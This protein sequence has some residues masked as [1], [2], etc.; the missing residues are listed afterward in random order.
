VSWIL[1]WYE[2]VA[3]CRL[4]IALSSFKMIATTAIS[5]AINERMASID[6]E[7]AVFVCCRMERVGLASPSPKLDDVAINMFQ[8]FP[9]PTKKKKKKRKSREVSG[10]IVEKMQREVNK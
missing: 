7:E 8:R 5:R 6:H 4:L 9:R 3:I 2:V 1:L 10:E